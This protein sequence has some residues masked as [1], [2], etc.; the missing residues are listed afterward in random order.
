[1]IRRLVDLS[2]TANLARLQVRE[3]LPGGLEYV[4][5]SGH[6]PPTV[7]EGG[8]RRLR[9]DYS[10]PVSR[11]I[12][13]TYEVQPQA[14]GVYDLRGE[15]VLTDTQRLKRTIVLP[16]G[17]ITVTEACELATATPTATEMA[18]ATATATEVPASATATAT[19]RPRGL[20]LPVLVK[21]EVCE[22]EEEHADVVL[23]IDA[24]T[25]MLGEGGGGR[26]KLGAAQAAVREFI[27][28]MD[29]SRDQ[30]GVI[31][32]NSS[33]RLLQGLTGERRLLES[34]LGRIE[35]G[36]G[37]RLDLAVEAGEAELLSVRRRGGN[38][39]VLIVLTDGR[40]TGVEPGVAVEA[41]G[42]AKGAG[43]RVITIGLGGDADAET[44]RAMAS[45]SGDYHHA[46]GGQELA[47]IYRTVAVEIPCPADKFWPRRR[48]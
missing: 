32:F 27:G 46:P 40:V 2:A 5:G 8:G 14:L 33:A 30:A 43:L 26:T 12:T 47:G 34:G 16:G 41:A 42:R 19:A 15:V 18:V 7:L 36:V 35:V 28:L 3:R 23:A 29:L 21:D 38:A 25:S 48:G 4:A 31:A 45:S 22:V 37:T 9:W 24:S 11:E 20:Y 17:V 1:M 13:I 39:G 10:Q 6:P 44:L